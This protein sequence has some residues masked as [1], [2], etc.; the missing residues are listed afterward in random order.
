[1]VRAVVEGLGDAICFER[2][3][4]RSCLL[5]SASRRFRLIDATL[6]YHMFAEISMNA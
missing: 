2:V 6:F 5:G 3:Q 1:M 4:M